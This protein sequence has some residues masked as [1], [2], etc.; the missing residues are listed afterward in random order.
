MALDA[1]GL[2]GFLYMYHFRHRLGGTG[3]NGAEHY[4]G[5]V[6]GNDPQAVIDRQKAHKIGSGAKIMKAAF[7]QGCDPVLCRVWVGTRNDE[8]RFKRSGHF[9]RACPVCK[10]GGDT[11]PL[12]VGSTQP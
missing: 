3:R 4:V 5:F 8:R 7:D 2:P 11:L 6:L 1:W 12:L 10:N 9:D